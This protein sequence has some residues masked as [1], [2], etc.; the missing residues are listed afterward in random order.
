MCLIYDYN[1]CFNGSPYDIS[2][3]YNYKSV[4]PYYIV[5]H[6]AKLI[7]KQPHLAKYICKQPHMA[8]YIGQT[9]SHD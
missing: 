1:H 8:N 2:S 9:T 5:I 4:W 3:Y 7:C 6:L